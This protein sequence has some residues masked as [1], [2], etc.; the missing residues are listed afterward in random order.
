VAI[1]CFRCNTSEHEATGI[2]PFEAMFGVKAFD[3][4][5][6][7]GWRTFLDEQE[8]RSLGEQLQSLHN[9]LYRR[10]IKASLQLLNSTKKL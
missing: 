7:I 9:E 3:F 6:R 2:S 1:A 5:T 8:E 4:D 10:G